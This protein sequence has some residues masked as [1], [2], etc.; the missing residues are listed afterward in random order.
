MY[1]SVKGVQAIDGY[2]L[3]VTFKN[4]EKKILDIEPYLGLGRFAEL[5]DKS[6]F[7]SGRV[8]FDSIEWAN[9]L[10][11]D[12]EFIYHKSKEY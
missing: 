5:K 6:V 1:L 11:L 9:H 10:D 7:N 8:H 2:K 4:D 3:I 12:S